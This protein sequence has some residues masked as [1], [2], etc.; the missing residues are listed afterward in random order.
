MKG[1]P[2]CSQ[3]SSQV[4]SCK[5]GGLRGHS[6]LD[7]PLGRPPTSLSP[8]LRR[9]FLSFPRTLVGPAQSCLQPTSSECPTSV[10]PICG[11]HIPRAEP[12]LG[13]SPMPFRL[14]ARGASP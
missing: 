4:Q 13:Q 6:P 9:G 10:G 8:L 3:V 1:R 11:A 14:K 12:H 7:A 5:G 2:V